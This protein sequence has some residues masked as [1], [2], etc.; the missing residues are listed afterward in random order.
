[1]AGSIKLYIS[2]VIINNPVDDGGA[3]DE[4]EAVVSKANEDYDA[5]DDGDMALE[6]TDAI[7]GGANPKEIFKTELKNI[8]EEKMGASEMLKRRSR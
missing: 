1:M 3:T 8:A 5:S 7:E 2:S 6:I 4:L